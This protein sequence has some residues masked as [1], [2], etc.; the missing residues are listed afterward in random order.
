MIVKFSN[1]EY[2]DF[3]L[4]TGKFS[5]ASKN[6]SSSYW[7]ADCVKKSLT[8]LDEK[9]NTDTWDLIK[10]GSDEN[11]SMVTGVPDVIIC[12]DR[13]YMLFEASSSGTM[14]IAINGNLK[15]FVLQHDANGNAVASSQPAS[16]SQVDSNCNKMS[17][18]ELSSRGD[19]HK[20]VSSKNAR[21]LSESN[22]D[23][24]TKYPG[25]IRCGKY[26]MYILLD[27]NDSIF[28]APY[29][30]MKYSNYMFRRN[31][32]YKQLNGSNSV[33]DKTCVGS[34][35]AQFYTKPGHG[36]YNFA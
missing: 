15:N 24:L 6:S 3:D 2:L 30:P 9:V 32:T 34:S 10:N 17:F 28:Y 13:N 5:T 1:Y 31:G 29:T 23:I 16:N 20:L 25:A 22:T 26:F 27:R 11:S 4:K 18:A 21:P 7:H 19:T 8:D 35:I 36:A 33:P 12:G 14:H